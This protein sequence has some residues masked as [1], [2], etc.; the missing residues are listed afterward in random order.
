[1]LK[2][3]FSFGLSDTSSFH[4]AI[5]S[6]SSPY[7]G[8]LHKI[9]SL[10]S[11]TAADL[12]FHVSPLHLYFRTLLSDAPIGYPITAQLSFP[13]TT[14]LTHLRHIFPICA[15]F[16]AFVAQDPFVGQSQVS[17]SLDVNMKFPRDPR[18]SICL[19]EVTFTHHTTSH[20]LS[21]SQ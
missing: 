17:A 20:H 13:A 19:Q 5:N 1:M 9:H 2:S 14:D 10:A 16:S 11:L 8:S 7:A 6:P 18:S 21:S 4:V 3:T 12:F 15:M